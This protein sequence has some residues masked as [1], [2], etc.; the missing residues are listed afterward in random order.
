MRYRKTIKWQ[1][2]IAAALM[3]AFIVS[4]SGGHY[5]KIRY[6]KEVGQAFQQYEMIDDYNYYYA[7][8]ANRPSA[9]IGIDSEFEFSSDLWTFIEADEFETMVGRL[10][11]PEY[12]FLSGSFILTPDERQAGVWYSWVNTHWV[13]FDG[14]RIMISDPEPFSDADGRFRGSGS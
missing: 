11:P 9:I 3:V 2:K 6:S 8:R 5:G 4:C 14:N 1:T 7:G 13:K 12:P 10:S